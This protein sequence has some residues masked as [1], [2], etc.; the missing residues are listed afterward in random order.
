MRQV[1]LT[2]QDKAVHTTVIVTR[3]F[4]HLP[5]AQCWVEQGVRWLNGSGFMISK[6]II[7]S[8]EEATKTVSSG[9]ILQPLIVMWSR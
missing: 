5:G 8:V 2:I 3:R 7:E 9:F 4:E 6:I 1:T